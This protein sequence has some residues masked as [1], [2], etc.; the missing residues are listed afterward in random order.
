MSPLS[1]FTL[2]YNERKDKWD[3][4]KDKT[5]RAMVEAMSTIA[6]SLGIKTIAEY[7]ESENIL[8]ILQEL[9]IDCAQGYYL[10]RPKA[11]I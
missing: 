8:K 3:L 11:T 6:C 9:K 2:Q 1:K 5:N 4:E 7:V 10:G